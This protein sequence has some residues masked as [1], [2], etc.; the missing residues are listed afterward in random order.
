MKL[1]ECGGRIFTSM[2]DACAYASFIHKVSRI[3]LG[4]FE[5]KEEV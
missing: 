1:Y 4:V 2:E 3:V 5:L